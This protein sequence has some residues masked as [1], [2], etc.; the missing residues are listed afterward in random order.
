MLTPRPYQ[1]AAHD[2]AWGFIRTST[3]PC[4]IEAATGAGKS[5]IVAL[6]ADT[7]HQHSG[8][9]VLCLCPSGELVEQNAEKMAIAGISHSVFSAS[10]GKKSTRHPIVIGTPGTVKNS[11]S[12]FAKDI[13]AIVIDEA[14]G[15]TPTLIKIVDRIRDA[16]PNVRVVG[17]TATPYR[18]GDGYIFAMWDDGRAVPEHQTKD[19]FFTKLVYRITAHDLLDQR[20]LTPVTVGEIGAP[21]Y[22]TSGLALGKNGKFT[23]ASL[24]RAYNG[25]GRKTAGIVADIVDHSRDRRGVM[26]FCATVQHAQEALASLPSEISAMVTANTD[27]AERRRIIAQ[28]KARKIKYIVN[29]AVLTTGFD[30]PHADVV[31]LLRKTESPGLLQQIIGRGLRLCDGKTDCLLLDYSDNLET[32]F[33]DGDI[34]TP[35]IRV[36]IPAGELP[37]MSCHCE[38]CGVENTFRQRKNPDG[39]EWDKAGYFVDLAG[40]RIMSDFGPIPAHTGR[41]CTAMS[42]SGATWVRCNGRWTSKAC[43]DCGEANDIA[44]R[45]CYVCRAEIV[46]PNDKLRLE[47]RQL[48]RDPTRQQ[49][50]KVVSMDVTKATSAKGAEMWKIDWMTEHRSF[51]TWHF[52]QPDSQW[53]YSDYERLMTATNGLK[54]VPETVSYVKDAKS[55]FYRISGFGITADKLELV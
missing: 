38:T 39:Y 20:Y 32:H 14:H 8:K 36:G 29:V 9:R 7:I 42:K 17:M 16:N 31:A 37:D 4:L 30:A 48:K 44:A 53:K 43:P 3:D 55:G 35:E 2:A 33:P 18:M 34:F 1:Q 49:C 54:S 24:D 50:D 25:H 21:K 13:G 11:L 22:D 27:K 51:Q 52:A 15:I 47:F 41:R 40:E 46:N 26:L 12:R 6:L 10:L 45:Y 5:I 28:F 19:P 23:V